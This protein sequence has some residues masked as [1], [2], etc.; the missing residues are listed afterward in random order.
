M[1]HGKFKL[2]NGSDALQETVNLDF[3]TISV[4]AE[5]NLVI[6]PSA[7]QSFV[8]PVQKQSGENPKYT[9]NNVQITGRSG[10]L[11]Y[12]KLLEYYK[13]PTTSNGDY[14]VLEVDK[15]R[16]TASVLPDISGNSNGIK[17]VVEAFDFDFENSYSDD[18]GE[19]IGQGSITLSETV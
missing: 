10:A 17:V 5:N 19:L 15:G 13:L 4:S 7:N 9:L 18:T 3:T 16:N 11:D 14:L 1:A 8:T 6:K 12:D 2:Y